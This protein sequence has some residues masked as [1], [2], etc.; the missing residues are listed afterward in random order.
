MGTR[1]CI[2]DKKKLIFLYPFSSFNDL[3][4]ELE[5]LDVHR[6][7]NQSNQSLSYHL[8]S[9]NKSNLTNQSLQNHNYAYNSSNPRCTKSINS[10]TNSI[11]TQSYSTASSPTSNNKDNNN[12]LCSNNGNNGIDA[13]SSQCSSPL[14]MG[15][16]TSLNSNRSH[17]GVFLRPGA[18]SR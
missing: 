12:E 4:I 6:D 18:V 5:R 2:A 7:R 10:A 8:N 15:S 14:S 3:A 16:V 9:N 11:Y 17:D 13:E 1:R